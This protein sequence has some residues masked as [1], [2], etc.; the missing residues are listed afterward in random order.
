M[1]AHPFLAA[2]GGREWYEGRTHLT[3]Q[4]SRSR[5]RVFR[6]RATLQ[7]A[8]LL[9][10]DSRKA[11]KGLLSTSSLLV[12]AA[13]GDLGARQSD[14]EVQGADRLSSGTRSLSGQ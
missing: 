4:I 8:H 6:K 12:S 9:P 10:F 3:F 7:A 11:S 5:T 1:H 14:V 13:L 2:M